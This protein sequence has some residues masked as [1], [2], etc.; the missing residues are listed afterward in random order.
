VKVALDTN[1]ILAALATHGLCEAVVAVCLDRHEIVLSEV[2]LAEVD[3]HL[4][5]KFKMPKP[6]V[7]EILVFLR[8]H[9]QLVSPIEVPTDACRD[10]NDRLILGT[11]LAG[12]AKAIVTGDND[13]LCLEE[14]ENVAIISPRAFY[15]RLN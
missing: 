4:R 8:D 6:L 9:C 15:E 1:V 2:I 3:K 14:F 11:A 13:L 5:G 10:P 12:G 7:R